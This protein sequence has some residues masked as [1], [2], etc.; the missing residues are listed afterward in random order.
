MGFDIKNI[1]FMT[2]RGPLLSAVRFLYET[3]DMEI[4]V[5]FCTEHIIRNSVSLQA[6]VH[7]LLQKS[8]IKV[9]RLLKSQGSN[10]N[11]FCQKSRVE[12]RPK[13]SIC[14]KSRQKSMKNLFLP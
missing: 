2:D 12:F 5:K 9:N 7:G 4:T 13:K 10:V 8:M 14:Q 6:K 1:S 11:D 3:K